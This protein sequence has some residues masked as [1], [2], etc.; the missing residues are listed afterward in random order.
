LLE[1]HRLERPLQ[2]SIDEFVVAAHHD[3][4]TVRARIER[5][6]ILAFARAKWEESAVEAAAH[7]G[8][9]DIVEFLLSKG[10]MLDI[11]TAAMLGRKDAVETFLREDPS[12]AQAVG[13]HGI[14]VLYYPVI[15]GHREIAEVLVARGA[16][17]NTGMQGLTPLHGAVLMGRDDLVVWLIERGADVNARNHEGK[18]PLRVAVEKGRER[19]AQALRDRGGTG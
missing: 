2:T 17:V 11:C 3:L 13:A 4:D 10:A 16:K 7:V 14:P 9:A 15:G 6:P 18:T 8:R 1:V 12:S 5:Q 19:V